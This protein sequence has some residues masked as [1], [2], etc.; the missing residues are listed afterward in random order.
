MMIASY[1]ELSLWGP[2]RIPERRRS[3]KGKDEGWGWGDCIWDEYGWERLGI[4]ECRR[5]ML[6]KGGERMV[7]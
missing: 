5:D 7:K 4:G 2:Q 3:V 1:T 6:V